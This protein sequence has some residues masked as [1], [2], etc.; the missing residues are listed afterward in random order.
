MRVVNRLKK[1]LRTSFS[2]LTGAG[3]LY[4]LARTWLRVKGEFGDEPHWLEKVAGPIH[5]LAAF[6]FLVVLGMF[7]SEHVRA[8]IR[9]E[10]HRLTGWLF[11]GAIVG[12]ALTGTGLLYIGRESVLTLLGKIHPI[13]GASLIPILIVHWRKKV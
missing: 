8:A 4:W 5:I 12:L 10:R 2:M 11:I 7:W 13:I 3:L 9:V 1:I 6:F